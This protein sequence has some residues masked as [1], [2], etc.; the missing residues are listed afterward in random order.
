M[1][2]A[3]FTNG[4]LRFTLNQ[5]PESSGNIYSMFEIGLVLPGF[6]W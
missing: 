3:P 4:I 5:I 1:A 6:C 2:L